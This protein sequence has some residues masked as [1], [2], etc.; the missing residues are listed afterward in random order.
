M[1]PPPV[2]PPA[3]PLPPPPAAPLRRPIRSVESR[4]TKEWFAMLEPD[5]GEEALDLLVAHV[6]FVDQPVMA[7]SG[8]RPHIQPPP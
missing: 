8:P 7:V 5:V 3:A 2:L 4:D 1:L 6:A